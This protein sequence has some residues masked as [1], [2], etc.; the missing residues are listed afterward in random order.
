MSNLNV[1][2]Y[3]QVAGITVKNQEFA[4]A[5][6]QPGTTFVDAKFDG[7]LGMAWPEIAVDKATP[8]FQNMVA[9]GLVD[10]PVFGVYLD[11]C[12]DCCSVTKSCRIW[13]GVD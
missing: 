8:V 1:Q 11:R 4:E 7:I 2:P 5:V 12:V 3:F 13:G 9:Q 10:K 6:T